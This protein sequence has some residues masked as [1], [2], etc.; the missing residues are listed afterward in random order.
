LPLLG[1]GNWPVPGYDYQ[2][3]VNP[4]FDDGSGSPVVRYVA[5]GL[6][7]AG[8]VAI[9]GSLVA[10]SLSRQTGA[11]QN[12]CTATSRGCVTL[13]QA[14]EKSRQ[15][16]ALASTGNVLLGTGLVLSAAGVG[17]FTFDLVRAK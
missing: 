14:T 13:E 1:P 3:D 12:P 16:Q 2:L 17:V 7:S 9:A 5:F 11:G 15:A 10:G 6:W 4:S 8:A